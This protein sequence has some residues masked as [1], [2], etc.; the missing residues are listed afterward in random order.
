MLPQLKASGRAA[1]C[2]GMGSRPTGL[3]KKKYGQRS[4]PKQCALCRIVNARGHRLAYQRSLA[5][6]LDAAFVEAQPQYR[7]I[8][9]PC[10]PPFRHGPLRIVLAASR[11]KPNPS[12]G[13]LQSDCR[14]PAG[15]NSGWP[16][17][18]GG[19]GRQPNA[20][21]ASPGAQISGPW[22]GGAGGFSQ[23]TS[24]YT[25]ISMSYGGGSGIRT[26]DTVSRIHAFQACAFSHSA[27]PPVN[28]ECPQ[29]SEAASSDNRRVEA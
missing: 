13:L 4:S 17:G 5:L 14:V 24:N 11:L 29:Y 9:A 2:R 18:G 27:T 6:T 10:P 19:L 8:V 1:W 22:R 23:K 7:A 16:G 3:F 28:V 26:H 20:S 21:L 25:V 12:P 15:K